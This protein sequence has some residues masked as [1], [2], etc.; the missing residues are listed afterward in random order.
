MPYELSFNKKIEITDRIQYINECCYGGDII[1]D[2]L[3]PTINDKFE[4]IESN[5]EDWGWF[6]WFRK[7]PVSYAID[8]FSDDNKAT[9][10]RIHLTSSRKK[11]L[12]FTSTIDVPELDELIRLVCVVAIRVRPEWH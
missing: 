3:L 6:I 2:R 4:S 7:G 10:F 1:V 9:G 11:Y 5:Q 12:I 8:I